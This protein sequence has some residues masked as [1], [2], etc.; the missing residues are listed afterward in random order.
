VLQVSAVHVDD[1]AEAYM[2]AIEKAPPGS[3]FNIANDH[4]L[5]A[6]AIAEV[7]QRN[8]AWSCAVSDD[9]VVP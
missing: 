5:R 7:P 3:V 1:V 2:L 8:M 9:A 6:D 4:G